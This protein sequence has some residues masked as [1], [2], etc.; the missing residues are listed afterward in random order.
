MHSLQNGLGFRFASPAASCK[1]LLFSVFYT[2]SCEVELS[3]TSHTPHMQSQTN[4]CRTHPSSRLKVGVPPK[5]CANEYIPCKSMVWGSVAAGYR[6]TRKK[7]Q[8]FGKI[9]CG[10]S[11]LG[12]LYSA[13]L[14]TPY[15]FCLRGIRPRGN[16]EF[17]WFFCV[18]IPPPP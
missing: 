9:L 14:H 17:S 12:G 5:R 8:K 18:N 10:I 15:D 16:K 6:T 3:G 2:H 13:G 11:Y 1:A 4:L 7:K